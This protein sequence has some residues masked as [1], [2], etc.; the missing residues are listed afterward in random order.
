MALYSDINLKNQIR[1]RKPMNV[2]DLINKAKNE[3]RKEKRQTIII[4]TVAVSA[5]AFSG[6]IISL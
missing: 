2:V 5:L 1:V 4:A 3:K 6:F